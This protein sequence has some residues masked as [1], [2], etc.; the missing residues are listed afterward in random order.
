MSAGPPPHAGL[1]LEGQYHLTKYFEGH[2]IAKKRV[3]PKELLLLEPK[4][5]SLNE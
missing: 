4:A 3:T 5:E 1:T 2:V